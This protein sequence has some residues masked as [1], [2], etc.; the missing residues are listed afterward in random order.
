MGTIPP[1]RARVPYVD[2]LISSHRLGSKGNLSLIRA[3]MCSTVLLGS[4]SMGQGAFPLPY[5]RDRGPLPLRVSLLHVG[6]VLEPEIAALR[7][8][9]LPALDGRDAIPA[10]DVHD[11]QHPP[12]GQQ[13][14]RRHPHGHGRRCLP[15]FIRISHTREIG[16]QPAQRPPI[17]SAAE[18]RLSWP[19]VMARQRRAEPWEKGMLGGQAPQGRLALGERQGAPMGLAS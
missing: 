10:A 4:C 7:G 5:R 19:R 6:G 8:W 12:R 9:G 17:L 1:Q 16:P 18:R 3:W 11:D 14:G 13:Q 15:V 2:P